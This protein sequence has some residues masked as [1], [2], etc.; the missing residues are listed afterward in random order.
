[1][2]AYL[3]NGATTQ[4]AKEVS[5]AMQM[6]LTKKFG[7]P[8]SLHNLGVEAKEE[9]EKARAIIAKKINTE[10]SQIIFTSGGTESN[11]LAIRGIAYQNKEKNHIITSAIEHS[12]V[13]K[14]C[15]AL[16]K[17]GFKVTYL[18][19][20]EEGFISLKKLEEAITPK[21][22]L[23][24]IMHANNE[25]G[26]LQDIR[27]IGKICREKNVI[28]HTDAVQS[29]TKVPIDVEKDNIDLMSL[30]AHKI[31]GPKGIGV[32]FIRKGVRPKPLLTGG[33]HESKMRA[34]TENTPGIV[35]FGKAVD[36]INEKDVDK[37]RKLRDVLI[38]GLEKIP[39]TII[40]GPR[41]D[42]RLVSNVNISFKY[43]EGE[44][45]L[46]HLNDKGIAV[47][48]GS[49]CSSHSLSPSHVLIAIGLKPEI[50]H[51]SV[52]LTLSKYTSKE[53]IDYTIKVLKEVVQDLRKISPLTK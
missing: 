46:Y 18:S 4:V 42:K 26:T 35:G 53:E 8:S 33:S 3:D 13:L 24:T 51:G 12:A 9:M 48:T 47:S 45:L 27:S 10:S 7:N 19:V 52:R 43:V 5:Q 36:I 38:K 1:M 6:M 31:H 2:K 14:T 15:E 28:F 21:T 11:N 49:A 40:N 34:G 22:M 17:E 37:M 50:A 44:S 41:G 29:F 30:S 32:L 39:D 23:V 20:D 25:I 16:E